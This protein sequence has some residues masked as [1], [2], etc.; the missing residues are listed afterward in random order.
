MTGEK[1][2]RKSNHTSKG[3]KKGRRTIN[4]KTGS[5]LDN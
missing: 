5:Y 2:Q 1:E 4:A 3:R